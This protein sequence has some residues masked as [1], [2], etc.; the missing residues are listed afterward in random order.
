MSARR[1]IACDSAQI[2][3]IF[4]VGEFRASTALPQ[5]ANARLGQSPDAI[6][7]RWT[8]SLRRRKSNKVAEVAEVAE[9]PQIYRT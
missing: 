5:N 4:S 6:V 7:G 1:S 2:Q 9:L 8:R 3:N